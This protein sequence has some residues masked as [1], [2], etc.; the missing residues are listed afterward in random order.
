M[1]IKKGKVVPLAAGSAGISSTNATI[2]FDA[3]LCN[4]HTL[5]DGLLAAA[6]PLS[7]P[8]WV[9]TGYGSQHLVEGRELPQNYLML[10]GIN[11]CTYHDND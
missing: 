6:H 2:L 9:S 3:Q 7:L 5:L 4:N 11:F 1:K 10:L 8:S